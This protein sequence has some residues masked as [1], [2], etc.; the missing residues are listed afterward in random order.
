[1]CIENCSKPQKVERL[2]FSNLTLQP[3]DSVGTSFVNIMKATDGTV[4]ID[5]I[6]CGEKM[7]IGKALDKDFFYSIC[8]I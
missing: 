7:S 8:P 6:Q 3:D 5:N 4:K 2:L 1:M